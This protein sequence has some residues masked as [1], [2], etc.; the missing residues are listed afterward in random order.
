MK[1]MLLAGAAALAGAMTFAANTWYVD[2]TNHG[3]SGL[4]GVS[5]ATAYGTIQDAIDSTDTKAGDTVIV[6]PG[7]YD[8]GDPKTDALGSRNR[9]LVTKKLTIK[10]SGP[11]D[12]VVVV[13]AWDSGETLGVGPNAVRCIGIA[14]EAVGTVITGFTLK[15]G[16]T[17]AGSDSYAV[18]GGGIA[19]LKSASNEPSPSTILADS[20]IVGCSA[21][22]G[23]GARGIVLARCLVTDCHATINCSAFRQVYAYNCIVKDNDNSKATAGYLCAM[24]NCTVY[25]EF[26]GT[27]LDTGSAILSGSI[28]N[29]VFLPA[30]GRAVGA[31]SGTTFD[32][33]AT[34]AESLNG[35]DNVT[36][37]REALAGPAVGDARPLSSSR[38]VGGGN[39]AALEDITDGYRDMD[40]HGNPRT[41]VRGGIET[42]CIGAV[43]TVG[44]PAAAKMT[45]TEAG[46]CPLTV[47]GHKVMTNY[48][49]ATAWPT[50]VLVGVAACPSGNGLARYNITLGGSSFTARTPPSI[51]DDT[52]WMM[53][54]PTKVKAVSPMFQKVRYVDD[55][56]YGKSGLDG[57]TPEKAYGTIADA[58]AEAS[59][60]V[61]IKVLPGTYEKGEMSANGTKNRVAITNSN[62]R[63]VSTE[64]AEHTFIV[65]SGDSD[66]PTHG[67][68][69][70][71]VRCVYV[72]TA[73]AVQ[74]FTLTG[75][76][77]AS[78][79]TVTDD[80]LKYGGAFN[81]GSHG[82]LADSIVSNNYSLAAG[83]TGGYAVRTLFVDNSYDVS[84]KSD[85]CVVR[86]MTVANCVFRNNSTA[87][88]TH[89]NTLVYNC[90]ACERILRNAITFA[91]STTL[92]NTILYLSQDVTQSTAV[93]MGGCVFC[94]ASYPKASAGSAL[95]TTQEKVFAWS[96]RNDY[97][98]LPGAVAWTFGVTSYDAFSDFATG[99]FNG[100]PYSITVGKPA[101]GAFQMTLPQATVHVPAGTTLAEAMASVS[102]CD[103][104]LVKPGEYDQGVVPPSWNSGSGSISARV[105][106][107]PYV[108][109]QAEGSAADTAIV[110]A[111]ATDPDEYGRGAD[112]VRCVYL[113]RGST[114]RG[115]TICGG[116]TDKQNTEDD[117]NRGGGILT[118]GP[119]VTVEDCV[120]SNNAAARGG[121]A[122]YG[123]YR[124]CRFI[125]NVAT[126]NGSAARQ[127]SCDGCVFDMNRGPND[128]A[129]PQTICNSTFGP[130]SKNLSGGRA[131]SVAS[132][133]SNGFFTNT[134]F[135]SEQT[136][137]V[138]TKAKLV[139]CAYPTTLT[140]SFATEPI[141]CIVADLANLQTDPDLR[142]VVGA[143]AAIDKADESVCELAD[144]VTDL[145]GFQRVMNGRM[146]IGALEGDWRG[147]YARTIGNPKRVAVTAA[148]PAITNAADG[149]A[150]PVGTLAVTLMRPTGTTCDFALKFNVS[151]NGRLALTVDGEEKGEWTSADGMV[152]Y[153]PEFSG[154][155]AAVSFR[156]MPGVDDFGVA[157]VMNA[158]Y[159][160][161]M[162]LLL[163]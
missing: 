77:P 46:G 152:V 163:R 28:K 2:A 116:R 59:A 102:P 149:V 33:C 117:D 79:S 65:G 110:G 83:A 132:S 69:P 103:T 153:R 13:G 120:I 26:A 125:G 4:D 48:F 23:G 122:L 29:S 85:S 72:G 148:T 144:D 121:G 99:D 5:W 111:S 100:N 25:G 7:V 21:T 114:L 36:E 159:E 128:L 92:Y 158:R 38:I 10:S 44:V 35:S 24:V 141:R 143:N 61:V 16:A 86:A 41:T 161:G 91:G 134:L 119:S 109:L 106:V 89:N 6:R 82:M 1:R 8:K 84:D 138:D 71:A 131:P 97:R 45:F 160:S 74:G 136:T 93:P 94:N 81:G 17:L 64:G 126:A 107:P 135:L 34:S 52:L 105:I 58:L 9:V 49:Y 151:G 67:V 40:F 139:N 56:N 11:R 32:H 22:R 101:A 31:T 133:E 73:S 76:R 54:H 127:I 155:S 43:E 90:T 27:L 123:V 68:G 112:A 3:K 78:V 96:E 30:G 95:E 108:T 18:S 130:N 140:T 42:V 51:K 113:S 57:K 53:P 147:K 14:N 154:E 146:D 47:D 162:I 87:R 124:R 104:V 88:F 142:P 115:F 20:T 12:S 39:V 63:L 55:D 75:S 19:C 137:A 98:L 80:I 156:Y 62:V 118:V 66:D 70:N 15:D 157:T 129:Y 150:I 145:S 50:Q 60:N 37:E